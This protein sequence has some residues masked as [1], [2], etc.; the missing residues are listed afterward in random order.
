[1]TNEPQYEPKGKNVHF[2]SGKSAYLLEALPTISSSGLLEWLKLPVPR[3]AIALHLGAMDMMPDYRQKIK[4]LLKDSLIRFAQDNQALIADGGT[5]AGV[6]QIVGEAY[7]ALDANFPLVGITVSDTVTFPGG[8]PPAEGRWS[9]NEAH[10]HFVIVEANDFGAESQL[11]V[12][13]A[14]VAGRAGLALVINGGGIVRSE[15]EMHARLGTPIIVLKGT[16]R[17]ADQLANALPGSEF[18][19]V[20]DEGSHLEIF[21]VE[22]QSPE[23][24]YHLIRKTLL[25]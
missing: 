22:R 9:L 3:F 8:P 21:D 2:A 17:Y 12:G 18:R 14:R 7:E 13:M 11:L 24:L 6:I 20:F 23:E 10:T 25:R 5:E 1:M 15:I 4:D 16:G 19:A